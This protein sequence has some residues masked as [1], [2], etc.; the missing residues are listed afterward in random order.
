MVFPPEI[1][2]AASERPLTAT[3]S[4]PGSKSI[5]NR[6]LLLAAMA[7]GT[8]V[9]GSALLSDDT[10]S[11]TAALRTLGID[12]VVDETH[13]IIT[14]HG[15][16]GI[17][18]AASASLEVGGAG[19]AMRFLAGFLTLGHGHF[20]LDGNIRMRQRPI[21]ALLE[22]LR[23]LGIEARA[24]NND[25]CPP[26]VIDTAST[27]FAGGEVA[28]DASLS[29]QFVS[30]LLMPAPL[31][32]LG[33]KLT[34]DGEA[35][36][37]FIDMTLALME[38][39]GSGTSR[40]ENRIIVRGGQRYNAA[41]FTVEPDATGASYFAAAAALVGG[42]VTIRG[43]T[44]DSVQ[45]DLGF[46]QILEQMGAWIRWNSDSVD[47]IGSGRLAGVDVAMNMMPDVVATLAAIAPFASS[48]TRIR[49]VS[50]IRHHE[51]DRIHALATELAR[52]GA[53]VREFDDGLEIMPSPL[54]RAVVE[55]YDDHRIAMAFAVIGLKL[56]G[57]RIKNPGCVAKTYP[58]FFEHLK[59]IAGC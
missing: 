9:V 38:R 45:G 20:R 27:T 40:D 11:M 43:L 48:P 36:R 23:Q 55:T 33:L 17:I 30:A 50:F 41:Q 19:T 12:A 58:E 29:S 1:E 26:V 31:W 22:A 25:G 16:G 3:I 2:I 57:I 32:P 59:S 47:V 54:H 34:V 35:A 51:S 7:D 21:G 42:K 6:A 49:K 10:R 28:I 56:A 8:S 18:P 15:R 52:L 13:S 53:V 5:T 24:E 46:L 37:P 44:R 39:W 4:V 14:V